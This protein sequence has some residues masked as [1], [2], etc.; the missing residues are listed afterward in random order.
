MT[1]AAITPAHT[2]LVLAEALT[3]ETQALRAGDY[4]GAT[5]LAPAK[6][7]AIEAFLAARNGEGEAAARSKDAG[8]EPLLRL[9]TAVLENRAALEQALAVQGRIIALLARAATE[10]GNAGRYARTKAPA[11]GLPAALSVTA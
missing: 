5:T 4:A 9:R 7:R 2:A 10:A 1:A 11:G 3:A 8:A 6:A